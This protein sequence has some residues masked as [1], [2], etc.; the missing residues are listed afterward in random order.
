MGGRRF[1]TVYIY[2]YGVR[3]GREEGPNLPLG[4]VYRIGVHLCTVGRQEGPTVRILSLGCRVEGLM[5]KIDCTGRR[6]RGQ[7]VA[8]LLFKVFLCGGLG[9]MSVQGYCQ[10][11]AK[12]GEKHRP[13]LVKRRDTCLRQYLSVVPTLYVEGF[14]Q[15]YLQCTCQK[16]ISQ[17]EYS[18]SICL[19]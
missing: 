1:P 13:A 17:N 18:V 2:R 19:L 12:A 7:V 16:M 5:G 11:V 6:A 8:W 14:P 3:V 9:V 15:G 4:C 10:H